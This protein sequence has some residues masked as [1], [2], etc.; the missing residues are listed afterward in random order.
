MNVDMNGFIKENKKELNAHIVNID[1][2]MFG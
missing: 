1:I 2:K